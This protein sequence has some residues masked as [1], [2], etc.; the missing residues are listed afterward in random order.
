MSAVRDERPA[1]DV[2]LGHGDAVYALSWSSDDRRLASAGQDQAIRLW[3]AETGREI[4][5]LR[6]HTNWVEALGWS[7]DDRRLASGS[8]DGTIKLWDAATAARSPP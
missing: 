6:G 8:H 7:P 1:L 5:T 4:A 3:D 2:W